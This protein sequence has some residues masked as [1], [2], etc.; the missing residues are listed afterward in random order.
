MWNINLSH[1]IICPQNNT[2][3][4]IGLLHLPAQLEGWNRAAVATRVDHGK[5]VF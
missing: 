4:T 1:G 2:G 3:V 5:T